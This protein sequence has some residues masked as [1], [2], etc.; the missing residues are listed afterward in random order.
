MLRDF[1]DIP[2]VHGCSWMFMDVR[3]R[4]IVLYQHLQEVLCSVARHPHIAFNG[5]Q[6]FDLCLQKLGSLAGK[7]EMLRIRST[8][9]TGHVSYIAQVHSCRSMPLQKPLPDTKHT[10]SWQ[11]S[12]PML[13][14]QNSRLSAGVVLPD[15]LVNMKAVLSQDLVRLGRCASTLEF[16][17]QVLGF[18]KYNNKL[19]GE[20]VSQALS[21]REGATQWHSLTA[22]HAFARMSFTQHDTHRGAFYTKSQHRPIYSVQS[23]NKAQFLRRFDCKTG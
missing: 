4:G 13:K 7:P 5:T 10:K 14:V 16:C 19:H 23:I 18:R 15:S 6:H 9:V 21:T 3:V 11:N 22:K 20:F 2:D 8:G 12:M 1:V 17:Y